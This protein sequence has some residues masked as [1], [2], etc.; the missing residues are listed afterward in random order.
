MS[1]LLVGGATY[2]TPSAGA[3]AVSMVLMLWVGGRLSYAAFSGGSGIQLGLLRYLPI[4][5]RHLARALLVSALVDPS[6]VFMA[7]AFGS[8]VALGAHDSMLAAATGAVGGAITLLLTGCSVPV[9]E[10]LLPPPS[11]QR[12]ALGTVAVATAISLVSVAATLLPG[13]TTSLIAGR[14]PVVTYVL[15]ILPTGWAA[16]AVTGARRHSAI[17]SIL[18]LVALALLTAIVVAIWPVVLTRRLEGTG[19]ALTRRRRSRPRLLPATPVGAVVGKE[20]RMW[21]RDPLRLTFLVIAAIVGA[22]TCVVPDLTHGTPFLLPFGGI[23]SVVIAGAGGCNLYG[24]DGL[25]LRLTVLAGAERAD[26]RGRQWAFLLITGPYAAVTTIALTAASGQTWAWPWAIAGLIAVL[27]GAT[28]L[29]PLASTIAVL[30]L[31]ANGGPPPTWPVKVYAAILLELLTAAPTVALLVAG[32]VA[33][34]RALLWAAMPLS[35]ATGALAAGA[36]G[37]AAVRRLRRQGVAIIEALSAAAERSA[38]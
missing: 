34:S 2:P 22:G 24:S 33:H 12:R 15:K 10:A 26:V 23:L 37:S 28:G 16:D 17:D 25:A 31:D 4:P 30:P 35:V 11:Q 18:P 21:V 36:L 20:V 27:G 1:S 9:V 13:L 3:A 38:A 7:V 19:A 5:R 32:T 29:I 14:I 6:L 8:L